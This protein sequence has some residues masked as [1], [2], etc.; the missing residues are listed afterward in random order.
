[1]EKSEEL[2]ILIDEL[3]AKAGPT[4]GQIKLNQD[5]LKVERLLFLGW[6]PKEPTEETIQKKISA[7]ELSVEQIKEWLA[8]LAETV[9]D[10]EK[11]IKV[12][13]VRR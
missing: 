4:A 2:T 3:V 11:R 5:P 7:V 13:E 10:H 8:S 6:K 9:V 12:C 1:M